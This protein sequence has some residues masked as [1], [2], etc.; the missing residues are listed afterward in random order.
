MADDKPKSVSRR[1]FLKKTG[2]GAAIA[3]LAAAAPSLLKGTGDFLIGGA[4]A[5]PSNVTPGQ[6][7]VA[8]V[9]DPYRGEVVIMVGSKEVVQVNLGLARQLYGIAGA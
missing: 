5:L 9:R 3:G 7:L 4:N 2:Q 1:A 8:Y 6:T